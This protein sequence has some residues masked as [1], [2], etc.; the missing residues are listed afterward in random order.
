ML[1]VENRSS[2]ER[3]REDG[4][5]I[6]LW[7]ACATL[8]A[9]MRGRGHLLAP[10]LLTL[11]IA[12]LVLLP[13]GLLGVEAAAEVR[14]A[15]VWARTAWEG[16]VP[17]PDFLHHLPWVGDT[18]AEW[19]AAHLVEPGSASRMTQGV[20]RSELITHGRQAGGWLLHELGVFGFTLLTLFFLL[21]DGDVLAAQLQRAG[22]RAFGPHGERVGLMMVRAIRGVLAGLVLVGLGEGVLIGIFYAV[23]GVPHPILF[24]AVTAVGC[25]PPF[26]S[27]LPVLVAGAT[28][29]FDGSTVWAVAIVAFGVCVIFVSDHFVRP[30]FIGGAT[31]LPFVLVIFGILGGLGS[32]G[33]LGLF[34]GPALMAASVLLWRE[35]SEGPVG[36]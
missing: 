30:A 21:R 36:E 2:A 10:G 6:V 4:L 35:W 18:M 32:F 3:I 5:A 9:H 12:L 11:A 17:V 24:G 31:R 27:M 33:L 20:Q 16:G 1:L 29:L 15:Y 13:L 22:T 28:L 26:V 7:P 19:W 23:A 34:L 8:R 14:G 25:M